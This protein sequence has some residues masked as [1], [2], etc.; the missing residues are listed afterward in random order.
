MSNPVTLGVRCGV[1]GALALL[2]GGCSE[3]YYARRDTMTPS[4]GNAVS[5]NIAVHTIDPWPRYASRTDES[6]SGERLQRAVERYRNPSTTAGAG[7]APPTRI[8]GA[9][10]AAAPDSTPAPR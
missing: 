7:S 2:L 3:L 8:G 5:A 9:S 1:L 10:G 6:S 4:S